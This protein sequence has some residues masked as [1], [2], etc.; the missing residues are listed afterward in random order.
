MPL[1]NVDVRPADRVLEAGKVAVDGLCAP[2]VLGRVLASG[3]VHGLVLIATP[4]QAPVALVLI[5]VDRGLAGNVVTDLTHERIA[6]GV[7]DDLG[8]DVAA[9]ADDAEE[10]ALVVEPATPASAFV[11]AADVGLISLYDA[12]KFGVAVHGGHMLADFVAHPPCGLIGYAELPLKFLGWD[13]VAGGGEEVDGVE[14]VLQRGPG[15]LEERAGHRME[16]MAAPLTRESRLLPDAIPPRRA[17]AVRA[18]TALTEPHLE[19]VVQA[20]ILVRELLEE[21]ADRRVHGSSPRHGPTF[22]TVSPSVKGIIA[23]RR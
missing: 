19:K 18:D 9:A 1:R 7:L 17:V 10:D 4:L 5:G 21:L 6:V 14:P 3:M 8:N 15:I 2:T 13:A 16:M 23:L 22:R 20:R 12:L 11:H